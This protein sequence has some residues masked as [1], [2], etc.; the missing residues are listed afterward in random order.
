MSHGRGPF[1]AFERIS[2]VDDVATLRKLASLC[3]SLFV[4]DARIRLLGCV[5][6]LGLLVFCTESLVEQ[7]GRS[8][9]PAGIREVE[10]TAGIAGL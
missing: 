1:P 2:P 10:T 9:V 6:A 3:R 5:F 4:L 7:G 8:F